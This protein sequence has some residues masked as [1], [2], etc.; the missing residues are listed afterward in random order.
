MFQHE[1]SRA[2]DPHLHS[3]CIL[4]NATFDPVEKKWKALQNYEMLG[5]Q[6]FVE[7][8]YYH[9]L[10]LS[11]VKLGYQIENKPRGDFEIKGVS[12][13][14]LKKFSK[15][16]NEIDQKTRELLE[17]EPEKAEGNLAAIRENIAHKE[18]ARKIRDIGLEKLQTIWDGQMTSTEKQSLHCL[19]SGQPVV[20]DA[21]ED[22]AEKAVAWAEEHLFERRSVVHEHELWRHALEHA[23][24]RKVTVSDIQ[25]VTNR[26]D[27]LRVKEQ[28]GKVTTREHLQREGDIIQIVKEGAVV[29]SLWSGIRVRSIPNW[30]RSNAKHWKHWFP[31]P[32]RCRSFG[33]VLGRAKVSFCV[34]WLTRFEMRDKR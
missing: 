11:L 33:A 22:L 14:L 27:Y 24:G 23:R 3:H 20:T 4:F 32:T 10:A 26:R 12:P 6:K 5:A 9:E 25:A 13:E 2:L 31:T 28:P 8:V 16:H 7:N 19:T 30:T 18:R 15:R 17:R 1:T 21:L 29:A 34:N